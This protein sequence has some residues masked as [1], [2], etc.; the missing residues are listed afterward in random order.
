MATGIKGIEQV[1]ANLNR[2]IQEL[3]AG[4]EVGLRQSATYIRADMDRKEPLIPIDK[5]NLRG[6]WFQRT[7]KG[8]GIRSIVFGLSAN[9]ALYVH[10]R[11]EGAVWGDDIVGE[12]NWKRKGS[13]PKFLEASMKRNTDEVMRIMQR[14]CQL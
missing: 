12:I 6:S 9:Y 13:G 1:T 5:G 7:V 8:L 10:E 4:T 2:K 14:N 3:E 11:M